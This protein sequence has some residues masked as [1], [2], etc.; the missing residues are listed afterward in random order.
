MM[1]K[2]VVCCDGRMVHLLD[3]V[4]SNGCDVLDILLPGQ[5]KSYGS[6]TS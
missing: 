4:A 1:Y 3:Q 2:G 5:S 6:T